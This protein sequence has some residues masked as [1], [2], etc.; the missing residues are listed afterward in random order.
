MFKNLPP[1]FCYDFEDAGEMIVA[2]KGRGGKKKVPAKILTGFTNN[3]DEI[4]KQF[5]QCGFYLL[6]SSEEIE[7]VDARRAYSKR[8]CVEKVFQALKSS[9]GMDEIGVASDDNLHGKSLIWF[10]AAILHSTLFNKT[11][12]LRAKDRKTYTVPAQIDRVDEIVADRNLES[13]KYT[14]RYCLDKRQESIFKA[15]GITTEKVDDFVKLM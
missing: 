1:W 10:V 3:N 6:V 9:L 4:E 12:T 5:E 7:T 2:T 14:R 11:G 15:C 8:D 13:G